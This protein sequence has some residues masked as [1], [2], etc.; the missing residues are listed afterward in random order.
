MLRYLTPLVLVL[1]VG[2]GSARVQSSTPLPSGSPTSVA[3]KGSVVSVQVNKI[4]PHSSFALLY[5]TLRNAGSRA[6]HPK[7]PFPF[8]GAGF[9]TPISRP[10]VVTCDAD[11]SQAHPLD[12]QSIAARTTNAGW[13][14]CDYSKGSTVLVLL[15][16]GHQIGG[17]HIG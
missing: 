6:F 12:Y 7:T 11:L 2:C 13:I 17:F 14:R 4:V 1:V 16:Q 3:L 10:G 9:I 5:V 15:W 8:T